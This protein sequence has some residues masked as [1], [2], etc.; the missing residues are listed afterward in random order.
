M[1]EGAE[2]I[3]A[4]FNIFHDGW[5]SAAAWRGPDLLLTV[6][7]PYL[8]ERVDPGWERFAVELRAVGGLEFEPWYHQP[9]HTADSA[10]L[11]ELDAI[12]QAELDILSCDLEDGR[13]K[14]VCNQTSDDADWCG[15]F[16]R[17]AAAGALVFDEGGAPW[18][19]DQL[20]ELCQGYW[21]QWEK[22]NGGG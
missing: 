18:D 20:I 1:I 3:A 10:L 5:I 16:L 17:F 8:A 11:A 19:L 12:F 7:I 22:R 13:V 21:E 2:R 6:E 9:P 4:I 15:G 14:L